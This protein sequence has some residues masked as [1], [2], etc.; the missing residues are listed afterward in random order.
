MGVS[1]MNKTVTNWLNRLVPIFYDEGIIKL[2]QCLQRHLNCNGQYVEIYTYV[3]S[4]GY[5]IYYLDK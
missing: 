2:A 3:E 5:N 1:E 4:S